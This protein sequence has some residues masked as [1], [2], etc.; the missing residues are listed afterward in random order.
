MRIRPDKGFA[1]LGV[2]VLSSDPVL[3]ELTLTVRGDHS[4]GAVGLAV[5]YARGERDEWTIL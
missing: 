2:L 4:A 5:P 3:N 1:R